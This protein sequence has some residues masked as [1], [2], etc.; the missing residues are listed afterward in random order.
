M[1]I[2]DVV[3]QSLIGDALK[4][5]PVYANDSLGPANWPADETS[6]SVTIPDVTSQCSEAG[7]CA[8]QWWWYGTGND[9][10]YESCVDFV[11]G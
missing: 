6:F 10:T 7:A 3:T 5:W 1:S 11:I 8:I 4:D 9:Q 2:V